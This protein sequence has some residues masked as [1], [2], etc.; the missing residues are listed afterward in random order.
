ME[1]KYELLLDTLQFISGTIYLCVDNFSILV[2]HEKC[3]EVNFEE[4]NWKN[5]ILFGRSN[6]LFPKNKFTYFAY[7]N[8]LTVSYCINVSHRSFV[9][10]QKFKRKTKKIVKKE[11]HCFR[12]ADFYSRLYL[13]AFIFRSL[14]LSFR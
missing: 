5:C 6:R 8:T 10:T 11:S 9:A 4:E 14:A 13:C 7:A 12:F 1:Q 2:N 3:I